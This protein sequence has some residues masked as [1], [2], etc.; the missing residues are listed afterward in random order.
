MSKHAH[1]VS[2]AKKHDGTIDQVIAVQHTLEACVA[3]LAGKL[4]LVSMDQHSEP[5]SNRVRFTF[6]ADAH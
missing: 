3:I 6:E 4:T 5:G 2:E 1:H